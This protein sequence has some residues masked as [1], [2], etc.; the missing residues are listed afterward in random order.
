MQLWEKNYTTVLGNKLYKKSFI[1][2]ELKPIKIEAEHDGWK[3][4]PEWK[5]LTKC[6]DKI[7]VKATWWIEREN[8]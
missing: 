7:L 5:E 2:L 8:C 3:H 4:I 1:T 6:S